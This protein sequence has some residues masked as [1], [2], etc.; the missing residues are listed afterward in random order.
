MRTLTPTLTG[1]QQTR[2]VRETAKVG[3]SVGNAVT[4]SDADNDPLLYTLTDG[5]SDPATE[6]V[7]HENNEAGG[8][9]TSLMTWMALP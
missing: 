3:D 9:D 2:T 1:V 4:A 7:Q 5:D 8:V 6:G